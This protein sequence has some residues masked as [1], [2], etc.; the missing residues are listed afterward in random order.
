[1]DREERGQKK[2]NCS[3]GE[4]AGGRVAFDVNEKGRMGARPMK[5]WFVRDLFPFLVDSV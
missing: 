5:I 3:A 2:R 4:E 1:M